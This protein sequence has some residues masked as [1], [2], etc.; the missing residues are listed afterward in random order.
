MAALFIPGHDRDALDD[1]VRDYEVLETVMQVLPVERDVVGFADARIELDELA[2]AEWQAAE[3][4]YTPT[5]ADRAIA[6]AAA[7][8]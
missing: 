4:D 7:Q 6:C 8:G 2:F 1:L 3:A 5:R